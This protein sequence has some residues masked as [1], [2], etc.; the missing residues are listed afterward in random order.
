MD[1]HGTSSGLNQQW[2]GYTIYME[3]IDIDYGFKQ[4]IMIYL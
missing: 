1:E 2:T 3:K 4:D